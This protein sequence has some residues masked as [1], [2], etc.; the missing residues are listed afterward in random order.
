MSINDYRIITRRRSYTVKPFSL[1]FVLLSIPKELSNWSNTTFWLSITNCSLSK[2][3]YTS[4]KTLKDIPSKLE[5][6]SLFLSC[7]NY[8]LHSSSLL[9]T[10]DC[11]KKQMLSAWLKKSVYRIISFPI[12][13]EGQSSIWE[14]VHSDTGLSTRCIQVEDSTYCDQ[15]YSSETLDRKTH[16][17]LFCSCFHT[18]SLLDRIPSMFAALWG[19]QIHPNNLSANSLFGRT[20]RSCKQQSHHEFEDH[21]SHDQ[22]RLDLLP[23]RLQSPYK[24]I[25]VETKRRTLSCPQNSYALCLKFKNIMW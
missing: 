16:A 23:T 2:D 24:P 19:G 10:S 25:M 6:T 9:H 4:L 22:L 20:S 8:L 7:H 1:P 15:S 18:H 5:R 17:S 3:S 21:S 11:W 12:N 14:A 13:W